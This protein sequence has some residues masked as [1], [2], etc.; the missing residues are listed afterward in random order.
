VEDGVNG[1]L[2][3]LAN[4]ESKIEDCIRKVY[5]DPG[6]CKEM[7]Q[8]LRDTVL[9]KFDVS[10]SRWVMELYNQLHIRL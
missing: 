10:N 4:T 2:L 6:H 7:G 5:D 8:R 3:P 1:F 9:G